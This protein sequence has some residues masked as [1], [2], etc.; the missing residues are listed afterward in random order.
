MLTRTP[1]SEISVTIKTG[2]KVAVEGTNA[3]TKGEVYLGIGGRE[4]R[5]ALPSQRP[6]IPNSTVTIVLGPRCNVE[7]NF[8]NALDCPNLYVE[9]LDVLPKYIRF[10]PVDINDSWFV[11]EAKVTVNPGAAEKCYTKL[12]KFDGCWFSAKGTTILYFRHLSDADWFA[13]LNESI[14]TP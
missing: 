9:D 2:D 1:V 3:G 6:F 12:S 4:F 13:V 14:Q 5:L 8:Y 7:Y 11:I 10:Q